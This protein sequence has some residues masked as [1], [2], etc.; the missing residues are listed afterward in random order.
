[1]APDF[2]GVETGDEFLFG[3]GMD[4]QGRWRHLPAIWAIGG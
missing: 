1:V 2:V 3:C 4:Y